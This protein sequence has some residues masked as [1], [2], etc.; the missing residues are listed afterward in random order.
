[1][2]NVMVDLETFGTL[3]GSVILS[4]GAVAFDWTEL[5]GEEFY[6]V[7]EVES[8]KAAGFLVDPKTVDWWASKSPE[9]RAVLTDPA[10]VPVTEALRRFRSWLLGLE[11]R[12]ALWGNGGDFDNAMLQTAY[13]KVGIP[14]PWRYIDNRCYRTLKNL[15]LEVPEL[16]RQGTYHNALDDARHQAR[17]AVALLRALEQAKVALFRERKAQE[18]PDMLQ[19]L[20]KA[21]SSLD[22]RDILGL[23]PKALQEGISAIAAIDDGIER[24]DSFGD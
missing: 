20:S 13:A 16:P 8:S 15:G 10:C 5:T 14:Q 21:A 22:G 9:A 11:C 4:I 18:D 2:K 17:G 7:I 3:P 24:K 23:A 1:M 19:V 6:V 12:V